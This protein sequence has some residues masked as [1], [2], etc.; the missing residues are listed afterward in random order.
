MVQ[1]GAWARASG[2][3]PPR[4]AG[5][6]PARADARMLRRRRAAGGGGHA[7]LA[8]RDHHPGDGRLGQHARRPT[9][10]R[11]GWSPRRTPPRRSSPTCRAT[12]ASASSRSPAPP[13]VVQPPTQNRED[14]IAAIDRF[15]LQRGTAIGSGIIVSL[16]TLFPDAGIDLVADHRPRRQRG[17]AR[18]TAHEAREEGLQA[19][20]AG[21]VHV[22]RDHPA[23][24]RP[25]HHRPR[26]ARGREDGRRPRR[27]RLH[28]R[29][30]HRRTARSS[31]S[32]AGRCACAS[33]RRR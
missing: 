1:G 27:A 31:A 33:T 20:A 29:H 19:G 13:R 18:S 14:L 11:T 6:V 26:P 2:C 7:A 28:R 5:A 15:Q 9:C 24:R 10:S 21:L 22:G 25:A 4:A 12:R 30:R 3:A 16:A 17:V 32:K 23:H 8:A